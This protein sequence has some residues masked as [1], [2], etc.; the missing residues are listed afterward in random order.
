MSE[1][2]ASTKAYKHALKK[3][4]IEKIA[5]AL[6]VLSILTQTKVYL[7]WKSPDKD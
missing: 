2:F 7:L 6:R 4:T 3:A 1:P 5:Q